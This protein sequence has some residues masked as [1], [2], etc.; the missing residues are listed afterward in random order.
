M[1]YRVNGIGTWYVGKQNVETRQG[2]CEFCGRVAAISNYDTRLWFTFLFVP[3]VPLGRKRILDE[4]AVCRRHR[5]LSQTDWANVKSTST[6]KALEELK[7]DE[8]NLEK[9]LQLHRT[10]VAFG[11]PQRAREIAEFI[12]KT[13]GDNVDAQLYLGGW[14]EQTG[15]MPA[16]DECFRRALELDPKHPVAL[17][18]AAIDSIQRG[19]LEDAHEKLASLRPPSENFEPGV[20][21][22]L[23][24]AHRRKGQHERV[25]ELLAMLQQA[26][27][28]LAKD[29]TFRKAARATEKQVSGAG[30]IVPHTPIYKTAAFGW[31]CTVLVILAVLLCLNLYR[32]GHRRAF[33]VNGLDVPISIEMD[34]QAEPIEVAAH[35]KTPIALAEGRHR[36]RVVAPE[37][38]DRPSEFQIGG[39]L[40]ARWF[41]G[42]IFIIDPTRSAAVNWERN[43]YA[44]H[45]RDRGYENRFYV[46]Q[47]FLALEN[48]DFPFEEFPNEVEMDSGS[49][50]KDKIGLSLWE[51]SAVELA[52]VL[53]SALEDASALDFYESHLPFQ[54]DQQTLLTLY[55]QSA[56]KHDALSRCRDYLG[57]RVDQRPVNLDWHRAYQ[58]VDE[59]MGDHDELVRQYDS[60]L[61][62]E[63]DNSTLLYLRGRL[64]PL[65][66]DS[67]VWFERALKVDPHNAHAESALANE[68]LTSGRFEE[69]LNAVNKALEANPDL[70]SALDVR[71]SL[72]LATSDLRT[73]ERQARAAI[74]EQ[75][76]NFGAQQLLMKIAVMQGN[77]AQAKRIQEEFAAVVHRDWPTDP[78]ELVLLSEYRLAALQG[79]GALARSCAQ[80]FS[81]NDKHW[82]AAFGAELLAGELEKAGQSLANMPDLGK[83]YDDLSLSLAY[84]AQGNEAEARRWR[85]AAVEHL[86]MGDYGDRLAA[87]LLAQAEA[88]DFDAERALQLTLEPEDKML[89][90]AAVADQSGERRGEVLELAEKLNFEPGIR[91]A[92][93]KKV[94]PQPLE[95]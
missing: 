76:L 72:L 83:G 39:G 22:S 2:A 78:H 33:L 42:T 75:P 1:P 12:L 20:F 60:W 94:L 9:A 54:E 10:F 68:F 81:D 74:N 7:G 21:F 29:K 95:P 31:T 47:P 64:E 73:L 63:P 57:K 89:V 40:V 70:D 17:R 28:A 38:F 35:G 66:P 15:N 85:A 30:T 55:F 3:I 90:L 65:A 19:E 43:T 11:E 13:H 14:Y 87:E 34:G 8:G 93:L 62:A 77:V 52:I 61:A 79:D 44:V 80:K 71:E 18:A 27:P 92:L 48:I 6:S 86:A 16:A 82:Q 58:H 5:L 50:T 25:A 24:E 36:A 41:S 51:G 37:R 88:G 56:F 53:P 23:A 59:L 49:R 46:A 84:T 91:H 45:E 32:A 69:G 26:N 4:C 67:I